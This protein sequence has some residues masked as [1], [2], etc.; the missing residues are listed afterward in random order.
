MQADIMEYEKAK[1]SVLNEIFSQ[2]TEKNRDK[3]L[4]TARQLLKVQQED[5]EML[6]DTSLS[7]EETGDGME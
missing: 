1:F 3:L 7:G 5:A 2:F 6:G 4:K